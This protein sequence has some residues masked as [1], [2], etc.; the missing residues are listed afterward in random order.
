MGKDHRAQAGIQL[1]APGFRVAACGLARND[2]LLRVSGAVKSLRQN[3]LRKR[4]AVLR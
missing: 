2:G 4:R 3:P 1:S